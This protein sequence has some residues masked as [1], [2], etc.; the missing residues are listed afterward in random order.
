VPLDAGSAGNIDRFFTAVKSLN[1]LDKLEIRNVV[2]GLLSPTERDSYVTL[3]YHRAAINVEFLLTIKDL[4][5]FQ[6]IGALA[7]TILETS[8]ELWL[9]RRDP[10]AAGKIKLFVDLEK[11]KTAKKILAFKAKYPKART[12]DT[13]PLELF[14]AN[15]QTR[16]LQEKQKRWS[17]I[18]R[19]THWS[20]ATLEQ[21]CRD[22]GC[23]F[24][25]L[26]QVHYSELSWYVH[27]GVTGVAN[28]QGETL[29]LMCG[30]AF[31][32]VMTS[33]ALILEAV[34]DEFKIHRADDTLKNK[35]VFAK[36]LPF[37]NTEAEQLA[38]ARALGL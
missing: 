2:G 32:I 31:Q 12:G 20:L 10:D 30:V 11:L 19:V 16:L 13:K 8:V 34:I 9:I 7:R 17:G 33:Y 25:E 24:D 18:G 26:Y 21:R 37:T 35:I 29:S 4:K 14:V 1:E 28:V 38:L 22:L 23:E 5:Q 27:S 3:N 15:G 36:M 6:A